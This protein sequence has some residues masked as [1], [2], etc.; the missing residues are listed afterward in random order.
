MGREPRSLYNSAL[1]FDQL[2]GR[3]EAIRRME[4]ALRIYEQIKDPSQ[5]NARTK[6]AEW[7]DEG[8]EADVAGDLPLS[9][10]ELA[11][12]KRRRARYVLYKMYRSMS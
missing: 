8:G 12:T 11:L 7:R 4:E 5:D 9:P 2:G 10:N 6:L 1:A 3:V